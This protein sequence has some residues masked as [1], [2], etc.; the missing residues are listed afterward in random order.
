VGD[1]TSLSRAY[2]VIRDGAAWS[3]PDKELIEAEYRAPVDTEKVPR[4]SQ[5]ALDPQTE[6]GYTLE[7]RTGELLVAEK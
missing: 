7:P 6:F 4:A 5:S 2:G 3:S 1:V